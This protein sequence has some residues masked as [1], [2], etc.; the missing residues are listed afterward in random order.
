MK[1]FTASL[2]AALLALALSG[3]TATAE[4][5]A[6]RLAAGLSFRYRYEHVAAGDHR[7][8]GTHLVHLQAG[9]GPIGRLSAYHFAI[10]NA[11]APAFSTR[12]TGLRLA[13]TR[14]WGGASV[15][16]LPRR[17]PSATS[18]G[19]PTAISSSVTVPAAGGQR[20]GCIASRPRMADAG[21]GTSSTCSSA[22]PSA[23]AGR[24]I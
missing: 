12:T 21:W 3:T 19:T 22:A 14:P 1:R 10:D 5:G 18:A 20:R 7:Q 9:A 15:G 11:D 4:D 2:S 16:Y 24:S 17:R 8:D 23:S 13:G 6:E